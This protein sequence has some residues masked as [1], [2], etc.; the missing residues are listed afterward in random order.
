MLEEAAKGTGK[1]SHKGFEWQL[2]QFL[3]YFRFLSINHN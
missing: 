3:W 2:K 1:P